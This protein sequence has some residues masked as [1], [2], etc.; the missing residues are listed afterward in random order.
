MRRFTHSLTQLAFRSIAGVMLMCL[1][2]LS[3]VFADSGPSSQEPLETTLPP[4]VM[5]DA[6]W[7]TLWWKYSFL[8]T[9]YPLEEVQKMIAREEDERARL[10]GIRMHV[11]DP[12]E[13]LQDSAT[14][15]FHNA[16][17]FDV[18]YNAV[19]CHAMKQCPRWVNT[20]APDSKEFSWPD[21]PLR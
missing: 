7:Q 19:A 2:P 11:T 17:S 4:E 18:C 14:A 1:L 21:E 5:Q 6:E 8:L 13:R 10:L 9:V 20:C 3:S 16:D 12:T 15:M